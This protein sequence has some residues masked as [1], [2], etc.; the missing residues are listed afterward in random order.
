MPRLNLGIAEK[1]YP[2]DDDG[3]SLLDRFSGRLLVVGSAR[4]VWDDLKTLGFSVGALPRTDVMC[5]NDIV[6]HFPGTV[7]HF[8]SNDTK[9]IPKW[10]AARRRLLSKPYG[11]PQYVHTCR[12]GNA[13]N[14]PW[15][16][17]GTSALGAV[18][19]GLALGYA[20]VVL[21]GIPL[22]DTGH[23]FDPPW[24]G[25]NFVREVGVKGSGRMKYWEDANDRVF[26][27]RVHAVSG[28]LVDV[29]GGD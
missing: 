2:K 18:Y 20:P 5:V 15:P 23:Y 17:H 4:C 16:G 8:F 12:K 7:K 21:C 13:C 3:N 24:I 19:T 22:D 9:T 27:G 11:F 6:M 28:R 14:W 29:L 10:I 25:S 26:D 1:E